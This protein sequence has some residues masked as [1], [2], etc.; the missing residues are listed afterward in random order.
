M[1]W[2]LASGAIALVTG[3]I[4]L[5][6]SSL[7]RTF[8]NLFNR[9]IADVDKELYHV[10]IVA[11]IILILVATWLVLTGMA[12]PSLGY[13]GYIGGIIIFFGVLYLVLPGW[14][15]PISGVADHVLLTVDDYVIA[16]RRPIGVL[17]ILAS[18]YIFY[19]IF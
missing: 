7:V 8:S 4:F 15:G 11:G 17:L 12:Y 18:I 13:L 1:L 19:M 6:P 2:I 3:L 9:M 16:A 10:R 5:F 14:L